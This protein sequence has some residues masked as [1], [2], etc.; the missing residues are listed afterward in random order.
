MLLLQNITYIHPDKTLLFDN[1]DITI[2][3]YDKVALI[4]NNGAGKSTLLKIAAGKLNPNGGQVKA[5][6]TLYYVPQVFGQYNDHTI[7]EALGIDQQ[8]TALNS[9]LNGDVTEENMQLLNDDWAIEERCAA[10]FTHWKL[11][12]IDLNQKMD[13]LSGG[14]KTKVFLAGIIIHQPDIVLLDEPT[15]HLDTDSRE[16]L[17]Q[18]IHQTQHTL[19]IVSHD[20]ML[21]NILNKVY[22]IDQRGLTVYG[23][24][25]DFYLEQKAIENDAL[26]QNLKNREKALRKAK[27][28][29]RESI[30]RQQ[31]LDAR[32]KKK[33]E[34][35][36]VP[37]IMMKT[38]KNKAESSTARVKGVHQEKISTIARQVT[39]LRAAVPDIAKM[40]MNFNSSMLHKGKVLI[41]ATGININY[42]DEWLW[43]QPMD[44]KLFSGD[45]IAIKGSN[46]SGKT[47]LVK[48]LLGQLKPQQGDVQTT[49]KGA[50]YIDQDYS[51]IDDDLTV[52]QQAQRFNSGVL[53]EHDIK[54]RLNGFLFGRDDWDK[55]CSALSGGEKMRLM[56][57]SL[58]AVDKA[59]DI[60]V[61]DEPTNNL[62]IKNIEILTAAINN[63]PGTLIVISHDEYFM[64]QIGVEQAIDLR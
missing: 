48:I 20:R 30:E 41:S 19:L 6:S 36:G 42:D 9:I 62:D 53:Q 45:R 10:A 28:V 46:G 14:Q 35:A 23:G 60:V 16:L 5:G 47:T 43:R 34:K 50:L 39:G 13:K 15:N 4:G 12:E 11:D 59:P 18:Y 58:T 25:Y 31:K 44:I 51:L 63:Y 57:C 24:N 54:I 40:K 22:E 38:L 26:D 32:G 55:P 7:A 61:L 17:Y 29:E 21:L 2:N 37:T 1:L 56:L 27:E 52:Y 3:K 8:L 49:Y 64:K 33:Q